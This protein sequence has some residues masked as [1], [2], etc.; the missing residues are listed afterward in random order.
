MMKK[1]RLI[2]AA[3][4][5]VVVCVFATS[6]S[7]T[8]RPAA[9]IKFREQH[10]RKPP[11]VELY[12]DVVLRNDR[13]QP[14]WFLLPSNLNPES[15]EIAAKGGVDTLEVFAPYGKGRLILGHFLGTGGFHAL[16]LPAHAQV[17]LRM[18]PISFWGN[19]PDH[20]A[21]EVVTAK[22]VTIGGESAESWFGV[23][24]MSRAGADVAES[25][26]NPRG[27]LRAKHTPDNKEMPATIE[28][29]RRFKIEAPLTIRQ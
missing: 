23:N 3:L 27:M 2:C 29:D 9:E 25:P 5:P 17:R 8:P 14:R 6:F 10:F 22:R 13:A 26:F 16:L 1:S 28:E 18:F 12:F 20:L 4:L 21:I 11:L 7:Q 15:T 24:P 19:L